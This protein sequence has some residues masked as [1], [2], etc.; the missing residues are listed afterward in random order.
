MIQVQITDY[1][2]ILAFWL[3]FTRWAAIIFQLPIFDQV[4]IPNIVKVL[5]T[6]I[7][8]YAFFPMVSG[9]VL[10]DIQYMGMN[11]FWLL[12]IYNALI[13]LIIGYFVKSI[14]DIFF[15]AGNIINQQ[16]GLSA[17]SYF[18]PSAQMQVGPFEKLI[19]WTILIMIVST[20]ALLPMFKGVF[21]SFFT[22]HIYDWG[23]M[24]QAHF[25]FID[26]FKGIFIASL[27]L[28]SPLIFV[29]LLMNCVLGIISRTV[30]QMNIILASFVI[31]IGLGLLVFLAAS[32]EF[33]QVAYKMYVDKLGEWFQFVS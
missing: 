5:A 25:F 16:V 31:N 28:A 18:D 24:A 9:E 26:L 32:E 11:H 20:G 3:C 2:M 10:K 17:I 14:M 12:T 4:A 1:T 23:R 7:I 22:I 29:N 27:M 15:S 21:S 30:P 19:H 13:G 8:T 33:F 6:V